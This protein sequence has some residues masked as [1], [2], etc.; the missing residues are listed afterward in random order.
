MEWGVTPE[1]GTSGGPRRN[2]GS[3]CG[4]GV[5]PEAMNRGVETGIQYGGKR[6]DL[7]GKEIDG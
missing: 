3:L 7:R 2:T 6:G 4:G 1:S 5:T